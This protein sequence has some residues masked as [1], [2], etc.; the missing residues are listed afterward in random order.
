M[1]IYLGVCIL[2]R[3]MDVRESVLGGDAAELD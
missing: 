3:P 1:H 2:I